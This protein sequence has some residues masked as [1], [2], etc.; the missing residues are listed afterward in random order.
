MDPNQKNP[1]ALRL[2][3]LVGALGVLT[4]VLT[5][6][7]LALFWNSDSHQLIRD[8]QQVTAH[9]ID[10]HRWRPLQLEG[11]NLDDG[12]LTALELEIIHDDIKRQR[13]LLAPE[14]DFSSAD[15][16]IEGL[17]LKLLTQPAVE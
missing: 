15:F 7:S 1:K 11:V 17:D 3:V 4:V 2:P 13:A 5:G 6:T 14:A 12:N 8:I 10:D 16:T 9:K